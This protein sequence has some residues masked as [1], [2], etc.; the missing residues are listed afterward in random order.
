[1]H[2]Q[3]FD[4]NETN[5]KFSDAGRFRGADQQGEERWCADA[6]GC[7]RCGERERDCDA[8]DG[9]DCGPSERDPDELKTSSTGLLRCA[10]QRDCSCCGAGAGV[11]CECSCACVHGCRCGSRL[12]TPA[13]QAC[14]ERG[15]AGAR[16]CGD[17]PDHPIY[18]CVWNG[19]CCGA[20]AGTVGGEHQMYLSGLLLCSGRKLSCF[21]RA[22]VAVRLRT[23][24]EV[25]W[26][27]P[28]HCVVRV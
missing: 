10:C 11:A 20:G 16:S 2:D 13:P 1:M 15:S 18:W 12:Q 22:Q 23:G 4:K 28:D 19:A 6:A 8:S 21:Q 14:A 5:D 25:R 24:H 17:P 7:W 27:S 3:K 9:G 26:A